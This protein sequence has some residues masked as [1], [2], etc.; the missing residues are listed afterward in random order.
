MPVTPAMLHA[1]EPIRTM[2]FAFDFQVEDNAS[3]GPVWMDVTALQP[4]EIVGQDGSGGAFALVGAA[5]HVLHITSEGQAGI[6][7]A[8]L[9][10]Y[11]ELI[12]EHPY[13]Q[14]IAS[15]AKGQAAAMR[16]IYDD[17]AADLEATALYDDPEIEDIRPQLRKAL[18]LTIPDDPFGRLHHALFVLGA[19][20]DL[21]DLDGQPME[22][23]LGIQPQA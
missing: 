16:E 18:G 15:R 14:D 17:E 7:A 21:R 19:Q 3:H 22:P 12:V 10:D 9:Q 6:L 1:S 23:L 8:S 20:Y 4:F 13:W 2:L 11:L 5:Q